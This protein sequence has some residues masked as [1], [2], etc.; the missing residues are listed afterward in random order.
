MEIKKL[1]S[2]ENVAA[3]TSTVKAGAKQNAPTLMLIG[4]TIGLGLT[5][6]EVL[7][8]K[9]KCDDILAERKEKLEE[10]EAEVVD[11]SAVDAES[12][13]TEAEVKMVP[14]YTEE[15]K[16]IERR[17]INIDT[18]LRLGDVLKKPF[19]IGAT[20]VGLM[21]GANYIHIKRTRSLTK[22]LADATAL[23]DI[24]QE[25]LKK[26]KG[27]TEEIVGKEKA[28]EIQKKTDN[29]ICEEQK[30]KCVYDYRFKY[31]LFYDKATGRDWYSTIAQLENGVADVRMNF[32]IGEFI[33]A[34]I[35]YDNWGLDACGFG[36]KHGWM[37][38]QIELY[39][40]PLNEA[41]VL[42]D[43]RS[44]IVVEYDYMEAPRYD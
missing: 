30:T 42:P 6:Y 43:G 16:K 34:N 7:K 25:A 33:E 14:K 31:Q 10:L 11:E 12:E 38:G 21:W 29:D 24:S 26:Y 8:A 19:A 4:A 41:K 3:A 9:P 5:I 40:K 36:E 44:A 13:E 28:E 2:K 23:Y 20:T 17:K 35:L 1:F 27:N 37:P 32:D 18:A 22:K 15:E 39:L